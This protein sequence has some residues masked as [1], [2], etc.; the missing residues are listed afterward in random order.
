MADEAKPRS[1]ARKVAEIMSAVSH[2]PK[3]GH[4]AHFNY[5]FAQAADV[6]LAVRGEM[7]QRHLALFPSVSAHSVREARGKQGGTL[8]ITTLRVDFTLEDGDSGETRTFSIIGEGEDNHDK[9]ANKAMTTA[10]K[11]A[12]LKLFMIPTGD[13]PDAD[14]PQEEVPRAPSGQSRPA[15]AP[16]RPAPA[17]RSTAPASGAVFPFGKL[18][19][20]PIHGAPVK[21]LEWV[22]KSIRETL[23][24]PEKAQYRAKNAALLAALEGEIRRQKGSTGVP[25]PPP[26][27]RPLFEEP[28]PPGDDDAPF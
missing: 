21:D 26:G 8:Y 20:Q 9:G 15:P 11:Q 2:V 27:D 3:A 18:K 7:A 5:D 6:L 13:D 23:D 12:A 25:A 17:P 10:E 14:A 16:Q 22:A 4:N 24:A 19:G 28:P 1:L